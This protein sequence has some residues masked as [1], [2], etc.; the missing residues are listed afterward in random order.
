VDDFRLSLVEHL[1]ELRKRI[2]IICIALAVGA[3]LS[4]NYIDI[5]IKYVV[6]PAGEFEFIYLSPPELFIAYVK[7]SLIVGGLIASP[8]ILYHIWAFLKP[9]LNPQEKKYLLVALYMGIFFFLMGASFAYFVIIPMTLNFFIRMSVDQIAPMFSFANYLSFSGTLLLSFGLVFQLPLLILLLTQLNLVSANTFKQYRKIFIVAIFVVAAVLTPPDVVSQTLMA[10][11][12][13][14][15]YEF[16]IA[17]S[18][19]IDKRKKKSNS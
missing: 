9:G 8:I 11:P 19:I 4:Y 16:S 17:L 7:I 18:I 15:L 6:K 2:I 3:F 1:D 10:L 14:V 5:I 12:M 13:I